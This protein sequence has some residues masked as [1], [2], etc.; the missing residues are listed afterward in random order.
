MNQIPSADDFKTI[1]KENQCKVGCVLTGGEDCICKIPKH[2]KNQFR[3][4][5][6]LLSNLKE[7]QLKEIIVNTEGAV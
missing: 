2:T 1:V 3:I 6:K 7:E 5:D 4:F